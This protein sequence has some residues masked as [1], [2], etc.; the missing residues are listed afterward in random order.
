MQKVVYSGNLESPVE[1]AEW[2]REQLTPRKVRG[3]GE[4]SPTIVSFQIVEDNKFTHG[5]YVVVAVIE[6]IE[7]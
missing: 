3:V 2:L 1:C 7:G 5:V 4:V 6:D